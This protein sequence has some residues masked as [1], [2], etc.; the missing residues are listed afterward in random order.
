MS[1]KAKIIAL[2]AAC[3]V[4]L[5]ATGYSA[6]IISQD[7]M[8]ETSGAVSSDGV[9]FSQDMLSCTITPPSGDENGISPLTAN[10]E[11]DL[12]AVARGNAADERG[13]V[14]LDI[15]IRYAYGVILR[16]E[17]I[18]REVLRG[19]RAEVVNAYCT[20]SG[21]RR[22]ITSSCEFGA[23]GE[24]DPLLLAFRAQVTLNAAAASGAQSCN[25]TVAF[26]PGGEGQRRLDFFTLNPSALFEVSSAIVG[27]GQ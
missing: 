4:S 14:C 13:N 27:S 20:V 26:F 6:Y 11:I 18:A 19:G 1:I 5:F 3:A 7:I 23:V 9:L 2:C 8:P 21:E 15:N 25:L 17:Q 10:Y 12:A 24:D 16:D 22:D